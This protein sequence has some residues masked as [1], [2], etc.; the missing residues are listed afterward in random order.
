MKLPKFTIGCDP[1]FFMRKRATGELISAIPFIKGT[2]DNPELLPQGGNIQ[3]DNVSVEIATDPAEAADQFINNISCTLKEAVKKLPKGHEM[4]AI[5]S[6]YFDEKQLEHPDACIFGCDPDYNAWSMCENEKPYAADPTFRSCGAHIHVGTTGKDANSFLLIFD[7]KMEF[8]KIMDCLHGVISTILDSSKEAI[9]RRQ[10][11]GKAGAHR[12]KPYGVEYRVLS[13]YWLQSP[14]TV[15]LM[16][17][18]TQDALQICRERTASK[19]IVAMGEDEIQTVINK[20]QQGIALKMI[21]THLLPILSQDSL[22]YFHEALAKTKA[23]D[24]N[25]DAEWGLKM[26]QH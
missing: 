15:M 21:E 22:H 18:L 8:V 4:V 16:Y 14:V 17:H 12:D 1:E 7:R 24:M 20:G 2:K 13:N 5:P 3:R 6:A 10:L 25:F 26:Y 9:D 11:Y 19:L 23:N